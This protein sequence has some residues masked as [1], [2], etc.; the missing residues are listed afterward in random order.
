MAEEGFRRRGEGGLP[1]DDGR[2]AHAELKLGNGIVMSGQY[3]DSG[4]FGGSPPQA[5]ASTVSIYVV[6]SD[7]DTHYDRAAEAGAN[8]VP[9]LADQP[10]GSRE[11]SVR[12]VEGNL[13]S[14]GTYDPYRHA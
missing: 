11:Y 6:V 2:I 8:V 7:P 12:D 13:W 1:D 10:Y 9:A 3:D 14:F 5:L 4:F